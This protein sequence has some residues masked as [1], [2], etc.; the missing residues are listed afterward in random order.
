MDTKVLMMNEL[1]MDLNQ[2]EEAAQIIRSGGLVAFPTE[3]VYGLGA[4]ALDGKAIKRIYVAKGRPQD[5]PLIVHV[6]SQ[7]ISDYVTEV[8]PEAIDLMNRFWPGPLTLLFKKSDLIPHDTTAGLPTVGLRMPDH[9][10]ALAL[11][12]QSGV[13]IAAPSANLSGKPSPT[14]ATRCIEDLSGKVD[15]IIGGNASDV[16][17]ESTIVDCSTYPPCVLRPGGISLEELRMVIPNI[18]VDPHILSKQEDPNIIPKAP[19]MKYRHYAPKAPVMIVK[20][21]EL[22]L[23]VD[24]INERLQELMNEGKTVGILATDETKSLYQDGIIYSLGSRNNLKEIAK[25]LFEGLRKLD[26]QQ[27]DV[28]L[29]EGFQEEDIGLAIMN[30]LKKAAGYHMI[31]E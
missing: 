15:C 4:N 19:G 20:L 26:D 21:S 1:N 12:K 25:H 6:A 17:L 24:R 3:T 8:T 9:P 14:E 18:I 16:G 23:T 10:I 11:I 27:V 31:S 28:I 22:N 29:S 5:N 13:P 2:L 7:D 30:R